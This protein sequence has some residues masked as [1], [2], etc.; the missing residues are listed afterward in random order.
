MTQSN[1]GAGEALTRRSVVATG[2]AA[3]ALLLAGCSQDGGTSGV[4]A[5]GAGSGGSG[6]GGS[7]SGSAANGVFDLSTI[8]VGGGRSATFKGSPIVLEQPK[9]GTVVAFSAICP[10]QGCVVAPAGSRFDCPCHGSVF[11]GTTGA[12][13]HGPAARG[14]TA[15]TVTVSGSTATVS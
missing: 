5:G 15:L 8:P 1:S 6:S 2:A 14:L 7:G 9:A 13:E 10:H 3:G 12:V 4:G 11:N